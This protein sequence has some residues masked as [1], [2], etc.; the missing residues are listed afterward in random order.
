MAAQVLTAA[1]LQR[2]KTGK[3]QYLPISMLHSS[4]YYIWP[5]VMWSR[6]LQ[7]EGITH[8]GE[9]A[10]YFQ[11]FKAQ[12]GYLSI[13]LIGDPDLEAFC[14]WAGSE[15]HKD[16]RVLTL[17][18][19]I[20]NA[21]FFQAEIEK[22]LAAKRTEDVCSDLDAMGIPVAR[23]N[24]VDD[25]HEDPQVN[26]EQMLIEIDHPNIGAM[27]YPVP[28]FQLNDQDEFPRRH[29]PLLGE[30]STE[31]LTELKIDPEEIERLEKREANNRELLK[32]YT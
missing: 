13:I 27:R 28:P 16:P 15:L 4:L 12:D 31:I 22:L 32:E 3:G 29:A 10:D 17:A 26:H 14:L 20:A 1:L 18:D 21:A 7:G 8:A 6:T 23:V 11:V 2:E 9:L 25:V 24:T 5:D 30:N 19:R